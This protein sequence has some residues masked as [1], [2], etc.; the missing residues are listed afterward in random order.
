M[1][2]L[3]FI[4][5]VVILMAITNPT[6]QEY[7]SWFKDELKKESEYDLLDWGI[8]WFAPNLIDGATMASDYVLFSIYKTNIQNDIVIT[9]LGLFKNFIPI[10]NGANSSSTA[11]TETVTELQEYQTEK[12]HYQINEDNKEYRT[13]PFVRDNKDTPISKTI[14][15]KGGLEENK[16]LTVN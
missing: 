12:V 11:T 6:K 1:K 13:V 8:E 7:I 15:W 14:I 4:G 10:S 3:L 2:R 9:T 16:E 5:I